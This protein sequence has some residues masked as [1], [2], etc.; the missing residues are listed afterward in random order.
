[1]NQRLVE[2]PKYEWT[3]SFRTSRPDA[4]FTPD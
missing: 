3:V 4:A 2:T 1:M